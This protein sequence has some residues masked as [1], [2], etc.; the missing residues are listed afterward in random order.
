MY[1]SGVQSSVAPPA[2]IVDTDHQV[3]DHVWCQAEH[4][5]TMA[6]PWGMWV[7]VT[8][9]GCGS[10]L[11][12]AQHT[13]TPASPHRGCLDAVGFPWSCV[14]RRPIRPKVHHGATTHRPP[15]PCARA[16]DADPS[17]PSH[18]LASGTT[19]FVGDR[20]ALQHSGGQIGAVQVYTHGAQISVW[21]EP[22]P[23]LNL[24]CLALQA[25]Y[26]FLA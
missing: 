14:L 9:G 22:G 16:P 7:M 4:N 24:S 5:T 6:A 15:S 13:C 11:I 1:C 12:A 17:H 2:F 19:A 18:C 21:S 10:A 25:S 8:T 3:H 23:P 20:T 26:P